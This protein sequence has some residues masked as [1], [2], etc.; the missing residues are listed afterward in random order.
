MR[1]DP[2]SL[3]GVRL[4]KWLWAARWFKSRTLASEAVEAGH[5]EVNGQH[6]KPAR[7]VRAGDLIC[8]KQPGWTRTVKVLALAEVRGPAKVAQTLYEDTPESLRAQQA[9]REARQHQV[10]PGWSREQGRPTKK[11]RRE[12]VTWQRWS[13]RLD[14]S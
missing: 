13:A 10:E 1:S 8:W 2:G 6:T 14:D 4:D 5:I 11:D 12:M 9:W 3:S 7:E